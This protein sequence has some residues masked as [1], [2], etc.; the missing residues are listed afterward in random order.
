ML[1]KSN[2]LKVASRLGHSIG[3]FALSFLLL[4]C[5]RNL[6]SDVLNAAEA[7]KRRISAAVSKRTREF[8]TGGKMNMKPNSISTQNELI[9]LAPKEI[10]KR[11]SLAYEVSPAVL[12]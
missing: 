10:K 4:P 2:Q 9:R 1:D 3:T 7:K 8:Q 6:N 11:R 5:C 12:Q